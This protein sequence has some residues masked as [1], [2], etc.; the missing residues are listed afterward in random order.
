M[1]NMELGKRDGD[2]DD[3]EREEDVES[4]VNREKEVVEF[5]LN[6]KLKTYI[7][8]KKWHACELARSSINQTSSSIIN[9]TC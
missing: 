2:S 3:R 4:S 8:R 6:K 5:D 7:E 1:E 9:R